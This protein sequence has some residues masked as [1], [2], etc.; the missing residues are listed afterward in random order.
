MVSHSG[1][2]VTAALPMEEE[3]NEHPLDKGLT[4]Q[5]LLQVCITQTCTRINPQ[6]HRSV[7][8]E[9]AALLVFV[10]SP[11]LITQGMPGNYLES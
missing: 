5:T 4:L 8:D 9:H 10:L 2:K 1:K 6:L 7:Q 11:S 3:N